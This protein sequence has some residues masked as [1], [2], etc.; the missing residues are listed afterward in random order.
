MLTRW[1]G[2]PRYE[3]KFCRTTLYERDNGKCQYCSV[4]LPKTKA[5]IDHV[6]P[7]SRGGKNTWKNTVLS[8]K[9]CNERKDDRTPEEANMPLLTT[10]KKP[11][12]IHLKLGK[13]QTIK[14]H[15]TWGKF[16]N[17]V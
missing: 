16:L 1:N 2:V 11:S 5:T 6:L 10:P 13:A 14:E 12:W 8:C 3:V 15:D 17:Y 7:K 9:K 4:R